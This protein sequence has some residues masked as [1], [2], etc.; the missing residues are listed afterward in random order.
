MQGVIDRLPRPA[1]RWTVRLASVPGRVLALAEAE[2]DRWSP[3][4]AVAFGAGAALCFGLPA[5]PPLWVGP[6]TTATAL[7]ATLWGWRRGWAGALVLL[8]L[9]VAAAGFSAVQ[10]RI[11]AVAGP[12]LDRPVGPADVV[13]VVDTVEPNGT[14]W[15]LVLTGVTVGRLPAEATPNR[16][17]LSVHG[18]PPVHGARVRLRARLL[19]P[20][21][22]AAP[23]A[24]DFGR[25]AWFAGIGA[26]GFA[27]GAVEVVAPPEAGG[28][29]FLGDL[30]GAVTARLRDGIGGAAGGVAAALVTGQRGAVPEAVVA[31]YR[32]S[33]LAHLLAISGLHLGLAAGLMFVTLRA[34]I[35]LVPP[36]ALRINGKKVAASGALLGA[37]AY[38]ALSGAAVPAQRA[39]IMT[40]V[41]LGGVLI[42]RSP[43]TFRVLATAAVA[44]LLWRPEAVAGASFQLSFAA[45]A[46]LVAA[47]EVLA[48]RFSHW[49]A[50]GEGRLAPMWRGGVVY[51]AGIL[52]ST[53][54]STLATAPFTAAHFNALPAYGAAANLIAIP[55][56]ALWVMPA[57]VAALLLMPL[58]LD[59]WIYPLLRPALELLQAVAGT[60]AGWPG[61]VLAV[62]P[63]PTW[64]VGAATLAGLWLC[65][66]RGRWRL[67][68]VP[69][70]AAM[71]VVP[72]LQSRPHVLVS[73]DGDLLA[74]RSG[75]GMVLSPGRGDGFARDVWRERAG[76]GQGT[77]TAEGLKDGAPGVSLACDALGC[78]YR[79]EDGRVVALIRHEAA[80]SD[81]CALA[82]AAVL[83]FPASRRVCAAPVVVTFWD[84]RERGAH[85]LTLA[86]DGVRIVTVQGERGDWPWSRSHRDEE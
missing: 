57:L 79:V 21:A 22:P 86:A 54:V 60:V 68:G 74:V 8:G 52:A 83:L 9:T 47:Y 11:Q 67:A 84:L 40:A 33:G 35:A 17:R 5:Q 19:P 26:V 51:L 71:M 32:D 85:A 3:W 24:F 30:R 82:D 25:Q 61:A 53:V 55:V 81:D 18:T 15:R 10:A 77:W 80:L 41:V 56:V 50:G 29:G 6:A 39:F 12:I 49:R 76:A 65:L 66:W 59:G 4:L 75:P 72:W 20:P 7:A 38:L 63:V 64:A 62:P 45:V 44:V 48:P 42:D 78:L 34:G 27:V 70:L 1:R 46:A 28:E 58:G 16:L 73:E 37:A 69:V 14:G 2:R 23:G 31:A 13:G 36:L 43:M